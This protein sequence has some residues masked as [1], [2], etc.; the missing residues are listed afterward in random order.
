MTAITPRT[1]FVGIQ[2]LT[3]I[4]HSNRTFCY[5]GLD[6]SLKLGGKAV[7]LEALRLEGDHVSFTAREANPSARVYSGRVKG[8]LIVGT[9]RV[10]G[11]AGTTWTAQRRPGVP[12]AT[13]GKRFGPGF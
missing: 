13:A 3:N 12:K 6:G 7:P 4:G 10:A 9:V 1:T 5:I 8:D 2:L 11:G